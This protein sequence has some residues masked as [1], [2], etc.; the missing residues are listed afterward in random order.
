[1]F[2]TN[3]GAE[4]QQGQKFC[5]KCGFPVDPGAV[6]IGEQ[7]ATSDSQNAPVFQAAS[8]PHIVPGVQTAQNLPPVQAPNRELPKSWPIVLISCI[9]GLVLIAYLVG[10]F[11]VFKLAR[12]VAHNSQPEDGFWLDGDDFGAGGI[13]WD[14]ETDDWDDWDDEFD[15]KFGNID[16][17]S[18]SGIDE[19]YDPDDYLDGNYDYKDYGFAEVYT[20][21][22]Y[23][24]LYG[25]DVIDDDTVIF[26]GKTIGGFCDFCDKEVLDGYHKIDRELLYELMEV[27]LIDPSFLTAEN[28]EYFEQSM[29]YCLLFTNEFSDLDVDIYSCSYDMSEPTKYYYDVEV[30]D[31]FDEWEVDYS[32]QEIY[33]NYGKT[34]YKSAGDFSMFDEKSMSAWLYAVDNYFGIE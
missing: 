33:F 22:D 15:D 1:M 10:I 5:N 16:P 31:K 13:D 26:N 19:E 21:P 11:F 2:C 27:H 28:T 4:V 24:Y 29:M 18:G 6:N 23:M 32:H 7:Q 34:Q 25:K 30:D 14:N 3:C 17:F 8:G 12:D 20:Y 9:G